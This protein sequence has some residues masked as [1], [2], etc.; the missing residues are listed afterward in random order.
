[1]NSSLTTIIANLAIRLYSLSGA[2]ALWLSAARLKRIARFLVALL[3]I[4]VGD[5]SYIAA[6]DRIAV[7]RQ[8]RRCAI[9]AAKAP[10]SRSASPMQ[11]VVIFEPTHLKP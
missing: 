1:M 5:F 8:R 3:P 7:F 10:R 4:A 2:F 6:Y 11:G 9:S